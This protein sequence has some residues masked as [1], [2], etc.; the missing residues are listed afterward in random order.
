MNK[1]INCTILAI[2]FCATQALAQNSGAMVE[3]A[4]YKAAAE[5]EQTKSKQTNGTAPAYQDVKIYETVEQKKA[6][7][8]PKCGNCKGAV[9]PQ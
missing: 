6:R 3:E 4:K 1:K 8:L 2:A 9:T 5:V 7:S